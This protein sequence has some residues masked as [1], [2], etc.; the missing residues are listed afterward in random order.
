MQVLAA[1]AIDCSTMVRAGSLVLRISAVAADTAKAP[2]GTA[3]DENALD[4]GDQ[5]EGFQV[6]QHLVGPPFLG[7]FD[8][9]ACEIAVE[10]LELRFE[11]RE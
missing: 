5:Q 9:G 7:Q 8:H 1:M 10:L 4:V 2:P 3:D 6:P 11:A